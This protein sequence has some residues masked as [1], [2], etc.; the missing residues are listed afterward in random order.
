MRSIQELPCVRSIELPDRDR[1]QEPWIEVAQVD[2][3]T[4]A[5]CGFKRLPMRDDAAGL[6]PK[7]LYGAI[8][9]D[10][11]F[12][13]CRMAFDDDHAKFVVGPYTSRAPAQ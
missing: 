2:T 10:V 3:L 9:P 5:G 11:A 8:A 4:S 12:G 13:V 6:A 7:V 1:L